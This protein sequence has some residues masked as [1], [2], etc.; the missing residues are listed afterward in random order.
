M[1]LILGGFL[2][3]GVVKVDGVGVLQT[4]VSP[5]EHCSKDQQ[6]H[7]HCRAKDKFKVM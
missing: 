6:G 5:E 2:V 3:H 1:E 4:P 7:D